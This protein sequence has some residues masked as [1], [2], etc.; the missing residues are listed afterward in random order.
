MSSEKI[1]YLSS[2]AKINNQTYACMSLITPSTLKGCS[3][4]LLK[5]R[6]VYGN[7]DRAVDRCKELNKKDPTFGVY[8]VDV[9]KW[10]AWKDNAKEGEDPNDELNE[11]MKYYKNE[12]SESKLLHEK[13]KEELQ[14]GA[15]AETTTT[16]ETATTAETTSTE[17]VE[18]KQEELPENVKKISYLTEDEELNGQ[19]FYCISFLTPEQL[20]NEE[21]ASKFTA[22]GFKIRGM[23][24]NEEDAKLHCSK[25]HKTD[26]NHNI[27]VAQMGHWVSWSDNTENAEDF[28]YSN[29]DLNNLMKSHKENQEKAKQFS[30]EQKQ[31][32]MNESLKTLKTN[33]KVSDIVNEIIDESFEEDI[34]LDELS[35]QDSNL[36]EVNKEL[37]EARK[38]YEKLLKEENKNK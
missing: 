13:R 21:N 30:I 9:G 29:K 26:Q 36:D 31:Q 19:K 23:F 3:K 11:L 17:V 15:V 27:Y 32:M 12:R 6:G 24:N 1:D 4:Y 38:M 33:N 22:R 14:K 28:E 10:I 5:C 16:T 2:D 34:N 18:P 7:E 25:L 20:E 37:E 35:N 8:K